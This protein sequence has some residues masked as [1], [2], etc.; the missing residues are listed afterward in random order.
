MEPRPL[1]EL[2]RELRERD[3][4]SLRAAAKDLDVSPAY[5]SRVER[6]HK[7]AS[8][9]MLGRASSYYE[10]PAELL[11]LSHGEVPRDIVTILQNHP[12]LL[13]ELRGRYGTS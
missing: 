6:G 3:G 1:H 2:L 13:E 7:R 8:S 9:A 10:V 12:E 4:R 5:L 11:A